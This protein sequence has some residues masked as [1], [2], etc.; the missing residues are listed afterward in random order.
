MS[1]KTFLQWGCWITII[2]AGIC[3]FLY[4]ILAWGYGINFHESWPVIASGGFMVMNLIFN[5]TLYL[6]HRR[7]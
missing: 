1:E 4:P 3:W 7:R 5:G 2:L 6:R